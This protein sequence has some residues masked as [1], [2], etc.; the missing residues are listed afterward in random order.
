MKGNGGVTS[1]MPVSKPKSSRARA[2]NKIPKEVKKQII[3]E[4]KA[5]DR[6]PTGQKKFKRWMEV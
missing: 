2:L 5:A 1:Q 4:I 3:A 6:K